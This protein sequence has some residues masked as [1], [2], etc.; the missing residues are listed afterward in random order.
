MTCLFQ[1]SA[2]DP[3]SDE[4][5]KPDRMIGDVDFM[6]VHFNYPSRPDIKVRN[7]SFVLLPFI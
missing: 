1:E 5:K 3:L 6:K 2:I 7:N 4:G